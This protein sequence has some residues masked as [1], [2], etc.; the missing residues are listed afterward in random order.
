MSTKKVVIN[1]KGYNIL[2]SIIVSQNCRFKLFKCI[3]SDDNSFIIKALSTS[4]GNE[5]EFK[6]YKMESRLLVKTI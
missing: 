4:E 2:D 1:E 5:D 6:Y 3:D